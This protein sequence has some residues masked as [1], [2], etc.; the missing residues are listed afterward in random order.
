MSTKHN[1]RRRSPAKLDRNTEEADP[2]QAQLP[3][4]SVGWY[5]A[6]AIV[7]LLILTTAILT[8]DYLNYRLRVQELSAQVKPSPTLAGMLT[9]PL[10]GPPSPQAASGTPSLPLPTVIKPALETSQIFETYGKLITML[11]GFVSILGVFVGYFVRKSLREIQEDVYKD[12]E[13]RMLLWE[14][15]KQMVLRSL[16]ETR[17]KFDGLT[18]L[19]DD[20]KQVLDNLKEASKGELSPSFAAPNSPDKVAETLDAEFNLE[21][22]K[23]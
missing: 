4:P 5:A 19:Y 3:K 9:G 6:S 20:A 16:D 18:K 17:I 13:K 15:E 14:L 10:V 12:V 22:S 8:P 1:T 23:P 2:S 11:L 21:V 7:L